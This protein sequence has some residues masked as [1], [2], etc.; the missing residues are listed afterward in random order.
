[1]TNALPPASYRTNSLLWIYLS[2]IAIY[3]YVSIYVLTGINQAKRIEYNLLTPYDKFSTLTLLHPSYHALK[4]INHDHGPSPR[5]TS[6]WMNLM[7]VVMSYSDIIQEVLGV[8]LL[9]RA[10]DR[11]S[12]SSNSRVHNE[13]T[14]QNPH[15][16]LECCSVSF[17]RCAHA[18]LLFTYLIAGKRSK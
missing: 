5:P 14:T 10:I 11:I 16:S 15:K 18:E 4:P 8:W 13:C 2:T 12:F 6:Q 7:D 9:V 3:L 1:M 17:L